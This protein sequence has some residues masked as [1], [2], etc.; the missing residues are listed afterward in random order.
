MR[1]V[2]TG[3]TGHI[4]NNV[5]RVLRDRYPD[6][7][8]VTL[9]RRLAEREL[10]GIAC[11][12]VIGDL[13]DE[14]FLRTHIQAGDYVVH[15]AGFVDMSG[16][17]VAETYRVNYD[18][19]R[20]LADLCN[21]IGVARFVYFGSVDGIAKH[22]DATPISEPSSYDATPISGDYGKS[23]AMAMEYVRALMET[24]PTF[25]AVML[26]PSAVLGVHDY[27]PSPIGKVLRGILSGKAELGIRGGY[28][29]VDVLDVAH[30]VVAAC[31][32]EVRGTYILAGENISVQEL[33][34]AANRALGIQRRPIL[35][36]TFVAWLAMPFV[37]VLNPVTLRALREPHNYD[38]SAAVRDLG[39]VSRPFEKTLTDTLAWLNKNKI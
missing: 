25:P 36:P 33:Y 12:Q 22:G 18:L 39:F 15:A 26:L 17:H 5:V 10:A 2:I 37:S 29:F 32:R 23:K 35:L 30:A 3:A 21:E 7:Q 38:S 14:Q 20:L 24:D 6:A 9:G 19:T 8:I 31:E 28:N 27:R 13:F 1:F 34:L 11:E 16:K 4:G